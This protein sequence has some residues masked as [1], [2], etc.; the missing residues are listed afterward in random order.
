MVVALHV[1]LVGL[2]G[3]GHADG[4]PELN[5]EVAGLVVLR[6][7]GVSELRHVRVVGRDEIAELVLQKVAQVERIGVTR[8]EVGEGQV[9]RE[10]R[11]LA[12]RIRGRRKPVAEAVDRVREGLDVLGLRRRLRG[13]D[14]ADE[15]GRHRK[16]NCK[17][18]EIP[19]A[20]PLHGPW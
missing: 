12:E 8:S 16:H 5:L 14:H 1:G 19:P 6:L 13:T 7:D 11:V 4:V 17:P 2:E 15:R 20:L 10:I 9:V 3:S 18:R